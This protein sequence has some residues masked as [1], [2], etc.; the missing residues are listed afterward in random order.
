MLDINT[1]QDIHTRSFGDPF[2][3][4]YTPC[5]PGWG[6]R[7]LHIFDFLPG[8]VRWSNAHTC[9]TQ[10]LM[11]PSL[12]LLDC[13]CCVMIMLLK[14]DV[15]TKISQESGLNPHLKAYPEHLA[16]SLNLHPIAQWQDSSLVRSASIQ[17]TLGLGREGIG[18]GTCFLQLCVRALSTQPGGSA[19]S[20]IVNINHMF[21]QF[22]ELIFCVRKG[23]RMKELK[24][25]IKTKLQ[26]G[27]GSPT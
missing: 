9:R 17:S 11:N 25:V 15:L 1:I 13:C 27:T 7:K 5:N 19:R 24:E 22:F 4:S 26:A 10:G 18:V 8:Y 2:W 20:S 21:L 6:G 23:R 14:Q 12:C 3:D 16:P